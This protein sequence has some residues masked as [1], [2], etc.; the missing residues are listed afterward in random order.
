MFRAVSPQAVSTA[1]LKVHL[2]SGAIAPVLAGLCRKAVEIFKQLIDGT[3][4]MI[5]RLPNIAS[6]DTTRHGFTSY[7]RLTGRPGK[8]FALVASK[9]I[10][11][12]SSAKERI[13]AV[14]VNG[15]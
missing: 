14:T 12:P 13:F 1:G 9:W 7:Q 3:P 6:K 8:G 11:A 15:L 10:L 4:E 2:R 5:Q